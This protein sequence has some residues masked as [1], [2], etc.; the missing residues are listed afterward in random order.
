MPTARVLLVDDQP[1]VSDALAKALRELPEMTVVDTT[2]SGE[3]AVVLARRH[4]TTLIVLGLSF[5]G[6]SMF[7]VARAIKSELPNVRIAF[8]AGRVTDSC[9]GNAIEVDAVGFIDK[10]ETLE[11]VVLAIREVARGGT[12][13]SPNVRDRLAVSPDAKLISSKRQTRRSILSPRELEVLRHIAGGLSAKEVASVLHIS[14]RTV[15]NHRTNLMN[16][17]DIHDRV[18]L[19]RYALREGIVSL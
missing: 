4:S 11:N 6:P 17:L 9:I 5:P 16:K 10:A 19:A 3:E 13:F 12:Y 2:T 1:I 14:E 18:A 8:L 15:N 7:D